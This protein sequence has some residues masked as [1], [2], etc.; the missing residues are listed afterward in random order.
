MTMFHEGNRTLQDR[1]G[2]RAVADR[3][4]DLVEASEISDEF[5]G[6]IESVPFFFLASA[7]N[8]NVD[9]SFKGGAPG[10]VR[11]P[12]P[13]RIVFPDYDGNRMYKSLGNI[14]ENPSVGLLFMKFGAEEGE[15][16][17]Y[18]RVRVS[19]N[20]TVHDDH[21]MLSDYPGAQRMVEVAVTHVFPN[22]PR[23]VPQMEMVAPSRHIP[24]EGEEQPTPAWKQIP[25]IAELL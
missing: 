18:L 5:K 19:G 25:P 24:E 13:D 21:P 3:I 10:F 12:S 11:V 1:Y 23:Y 9:C 20:A 8:G 22:C 4:V 6:F 14:L 7:A 2:G 16:A 15:G 17:L